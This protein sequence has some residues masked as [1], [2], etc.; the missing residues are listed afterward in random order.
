MS[1][2]VVIFYEQYAVYH[3]DCV[4]EKLNHPVALF[5]NTNYVNSLDI[6]WDSQKKV[7]STIVRRI[8]KKN[9]NWTIEDLRKQRLW[10]AKKILLMRKGLEVHPSSRYAVNR[11]SE[12]LYSEPS[13]DENSY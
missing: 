8:E 4:R 11:S 9:R 2:D 3:E 12:C 5:S 6:H 13:S 10:K 1:E 7:L